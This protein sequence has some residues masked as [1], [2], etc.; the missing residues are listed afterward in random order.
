VSVQS[1]LVVLLVLAAAVF[2]TL[3]ALLA[4]AVLTWTGLGW[5]EPAGLAALAVAWL[6]TLIPARK[7]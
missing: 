2:L 4:G 6:A 7:A 5:L 3:A 1:V